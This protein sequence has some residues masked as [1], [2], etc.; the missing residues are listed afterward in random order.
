MA[1]M[2]RQDDS[3]R[4][5]VRMRQGAILQ[6]VILHGVIPAQAEI[7]AVVDS[8]LRGNDTNTEMTWVWR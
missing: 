5:E 2:M 4:N 1:L 7:Q 6:G 3:G 8:R